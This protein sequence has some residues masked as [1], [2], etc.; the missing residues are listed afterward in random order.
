MNKKKKLN[1]KKKAQNFN[2]QLL[3]QKKTQKTSG[4]EQSKDKKKTQRVRKKGIFGVC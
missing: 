2:S 4:G 1:L 3:T